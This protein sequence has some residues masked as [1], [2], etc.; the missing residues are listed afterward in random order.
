MSDS[1]ITRIVIIDKSQKGILTKI[2]NKKV[3][4]KRV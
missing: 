4:L 3:S 1:V 2:F